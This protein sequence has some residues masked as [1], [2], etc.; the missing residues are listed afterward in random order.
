MYSYLAGL[1]IAFIAEDVKNKGRIDITIA[2]PDMAQVYII[3]F[4]VVDKPAKHSNALQQI[5]QNNYH[6]KYQQVAEDIYLLGIAFCKAERNI[7]QFDW[8][9]V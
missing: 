2:T 6:E 5:K 9:K 7:C 4:K 3:E 8:E 1:G